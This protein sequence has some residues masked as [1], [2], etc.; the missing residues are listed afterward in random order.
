MLFIDSL[1]VIK[2]TLKQRICTQNTTKKLV[3]K[4]TFTLPTLFI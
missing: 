4:S 1:Q 3:V 2:Q